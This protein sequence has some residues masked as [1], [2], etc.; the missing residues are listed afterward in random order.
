MTVQFGGW[1][2]SEPLELPAGQAGTWARRQPA[3]VSC[4]GIRKSFMTMKVGTL[5]VGMHE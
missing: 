5:P 3:V 4:R 1:L 2:M